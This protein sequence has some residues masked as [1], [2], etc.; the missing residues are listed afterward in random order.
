MLLYVNVTI[1]RAFN[2]GSTTAAAILTRRI[3]T[4]WAK[5]GHSSGRVSE[6]SSVNRTEETKERVTN[7]FIFVVYV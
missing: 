6:Q 2:K 3:Q 7:I 4:A 1:T 5:R